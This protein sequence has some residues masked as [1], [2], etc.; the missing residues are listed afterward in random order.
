M[1]WAFVELTGFTQSL[2]LFFAS[3]DE[4]RAFQNVLLS[5]P[6]RGEVIMGTGGLRKAR[7]GDTRRG[8]GTRGGIR[9]IYL[10][11]PEQKTIVFLRAYNKDKQDDLT[12]EQRKQFAAIAEAVR[13]ELSKT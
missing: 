12:T 7:W 13:Q 10:L 1:T 11:L 9:V 6:E 4:Y 2:S 5:N 8:K 3:D